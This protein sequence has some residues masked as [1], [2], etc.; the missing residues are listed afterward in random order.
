MNSGKYAVEVVILAAV[1]VVAGSVAPLGGSLQFS[2]FLHSSG[3]IRIGMPWLYATGNKIASVYDETVTLRG[4]NLISTETRSEADYDRLQSWGVTVVRLCVRWDLLEPQPN[5]YSQSYLQKVDDEIALAKN[6]GVYVILDMHQWHWST[7]FTIHTQGPYFGDVGFGFPAW[8]CSIYPD[9]EDGYNLTVSDFWF[10]KGPNGTEASLSNPSQQDRFIAAWKLIASRYANEPAVA[11]YDLF[12]E[13]PRGTLNWTQ[14]SKI[15]YPFYSNLAT[16]IRRID[17][18]HI[19]I[20]EPSNGYATYYAQKPTIP[21]IVFSFHF[22]S[23]RDNYQGDKKFLK[24]SFDSLYEP[25]LRWD[26]PLI[27]GEVGIELSRPNLEVWASDTLDLMTGYGL[28][29]LWFV[30]GKSDASSWYILYANGAEKARLTSI[31]KLYL[32]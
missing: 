16:E 24:K 10:G 9:T 28:S 13:P 4:F 22:Y 30:Y 25:S 12:N 17:T 15:L 19:L 8:L 20:Y 11:A 5:S 14:H 6:H 29:W 7:I 27:V 31:I 3:S 1:A 26:I 21:N 18:K 32:R 23:L 2:L